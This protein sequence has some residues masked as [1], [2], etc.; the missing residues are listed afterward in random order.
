MDINTTTSVPLQMPPPYPVAQPEYE[1][2][3]NQNEVIGGL[4]SAM[5]FVAIVSLV[6]G[7]IQA[8]AGAYVSARVDSGQGIMAICQAILA[9]GVSILLLGAAAS[10][11]AVVQTEGSDI[12]NLMAALRKLRSVYKVYA[13]LLG[14]VLGLLAIGLLIVLAAAGHHAH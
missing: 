10:F 13:V 9:I 2:D 7:S 5:K 1:F 8:A 11:K 12:S 14:I 3:M 6:F 4:A